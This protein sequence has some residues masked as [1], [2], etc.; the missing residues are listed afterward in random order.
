M[1]LDRGAAGGDGQAGEQTGQAG[2]VAG[3]VGAVAEV[4]VLDGLGLDARLGHRVLMAWAAIFMAGVWLNP[5]RPDL[6]RPVRA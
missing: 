5:P 2:Q 3:A 4:D 6:A 1:A